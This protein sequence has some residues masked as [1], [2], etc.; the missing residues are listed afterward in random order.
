MILEV[1]DQGRIERIAVI[2]GNSDKE[3]DGR[4]FFGGYRL[5][6]EY[7][8][9]VWF[10]MA[11]WNITMIDENDYLKTYRLTRKAS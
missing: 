1:E 7:L 4:K 5:K 10:D 9:E 6:T 2:S 8:E 3:V 11:V